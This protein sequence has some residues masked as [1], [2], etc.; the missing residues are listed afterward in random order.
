M[1]PLGDHAAHWA[2]LLEEIVREFSMHY[3]SWHNIP[4]EKKAGVLGKIG[5]PHMQSDPENW[6]KI[7]TGIQQLLAKIYTDNKSALK[8]D[9]W[10][11]NPEDETYNVEHVRSRR[12]TNTS[13]ADWDAQITFWSDPKNAAR[14]AQNKLNQA[15]STVICRQGSRSLV[16]LRDMQMESSATREYPSVIQSYFDTHTVDGVFLRTQSYFYMLHRSFC[17]SRI[18]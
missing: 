3:R 13:Q 4:T 9:Y 5:K 14:C 8:A 7:N 2:N 18:S 16:A 15:N 17:P 12:P 11:A 6:R 10:V 1:M